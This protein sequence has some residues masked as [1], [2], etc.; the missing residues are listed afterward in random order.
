MKYMLLMAFLILTGCEKDVK[1]KPNSHNISFDVSLYEIPEKKQPIVELKS[2]PNPKPEP[3]PKLELEAIDFPDVA[4]ILRAEKAKNVRYV[5]YQQSEKMKYSYLNEYEINR[6]RLNKKASYLMH[7]EEYPG[8][9]DRATFPVDRSRMITTDMMIPARLT[10][11][12]NSQIPGRVLLIVSRDVLGHRNQEGSQYI[13]FP[14]YTKIICEYSGMKDKGS[15]RMQMQ[16]SR[17]LTPGGV[18]VDLTNSQVSD[19]IGRVGV[20]GDID[21]RIPERYGAAFTVSGLSAMS[22]SSVKINSDGVR[23][24]ASVLS[25]NL[26]QVTKEVMRRGFDLKDILSIPAGTP[27]LLLP[28]RDIIFKKP[29]EITNE[30]SS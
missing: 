19:Q 20:A 4:P 25:N 3:E 2:K 5:R 30:K 26:G 28:E 6:S 22:Q 21:H 29:L 9:K 11:A 24:A 13:L 16:C 18:H 7:E 8:E 1:V 23:N 15:T 12:L 27:V 17:A 10:Q 14:A